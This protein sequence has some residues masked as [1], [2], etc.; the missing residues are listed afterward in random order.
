[1]S[2]EQFMDEVSNYKAYKEL[3]G[4]VEQ[5]GK[6]RSILLNCVLDIH[7]LYNDQRVKQAFEEIGYVEAVNV[8]RGTITITL[9]RGA[10]PEHYGGTT[11]KGAEVYVRFRCGTAMLFINDYLVYEKKY[12]HDRDYFEDGELESFIKEA[13]YNFIPLF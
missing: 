11:D 1:M 4:K 13:G 12:D 10:N 9:K 5:L 2:N 3:L 6:E 8:T 7:T